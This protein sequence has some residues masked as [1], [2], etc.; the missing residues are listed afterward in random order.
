MKRLLLAVLVLGPSLAGAQRADNLKQGA[1]VAVIDTQGA[2]VEGSFVGRSGN[3]IIL[4]TESGTGQAS[5]PVDDVVSMK[6]RHVSHIGGFFLGGLLGGGIGAISGAIL[7]NRE[8]VNI[9]RGE[10]S[11]IGAVVM[12]G[13]GLISGSI[14]GAVLG[15]RSWQPVPIRPR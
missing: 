1:H 11:A 2:K 4:R 6:V 3:S 7:G 10:N 5:V 15:W 8:G 14:L 12:G 9:S 13:G